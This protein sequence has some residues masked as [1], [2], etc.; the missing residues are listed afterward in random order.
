MR[1]DEF[2]YNSFVLMTI[3]LGRYAMDQAKKDF[4]ERLAQGVAAQFGKNCVVVVHDLKSEDPNCTIVTIVNGEVSGRTI[5]DG[6]SHVV[7][8]ALHTDPDKLQDRLAYLT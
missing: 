1:Y 2:I 5:G 3:L 6:P 7:L 8:K 4:L